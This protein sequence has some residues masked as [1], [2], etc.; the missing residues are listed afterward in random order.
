M[1]SRDLQHRVNPVTSVAPQAGTG[2]VNGSSAD[3]QGYESATVIAFAAGNG[4]ADGD[5]DFKLQEADDDGSGSPD[6]WADVAA[7]D[8]L[9]TFT[10]TFQGD[11][12]VLDNVGYL[13][14]KR[15]LRV[16]VVE[17]TT[18]TTDPQVAAVIVRGHA[19]HKPA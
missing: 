8:L 12:V 2:G 18:A 7:G 4:S 17:N 10:T 13:G 3:M 15:H 11:A 6:T 19:H 5:Y 9:G 14:S 1:A 16:V